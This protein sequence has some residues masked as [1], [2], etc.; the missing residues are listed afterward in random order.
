MNRFWSRCY[1]VWDYVILFYYLSKNL[2]A[3][4]PKNIVLKKN[5]IVCLK[6]SLWVL[7]VCGKVYSIVKFFKER[8]LHSWNSLSPFGIKWTLRHKT[9]CGN[10]G[11]YIFIHFI[12]EKK[13]NL[14]K[15]PTLSDLA[16]NSQKL[17]KLPSTRL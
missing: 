3:R 16:E 13:Q 15:K 5:T 8:Q 17:I 10:S 6:V 14:K 4:K 2:W 1:E 12:S 9:K 7:F 11:I